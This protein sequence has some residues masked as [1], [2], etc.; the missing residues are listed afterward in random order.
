MTMGADY[1]VVWE[2]V[3]LVDN[4]FFHSLKSCYYW[5]EISSEEGYRRWTEMGRE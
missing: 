3:L 1:T 2:L 4:F 5:M